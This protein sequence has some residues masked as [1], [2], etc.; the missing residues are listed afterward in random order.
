M[1]VDITAGSHRTEQEIGY[2]ADLCFDANPRDTRT[3]KA[4][5]SSLPIESS[6]VDLLMFDPPHQVYGHGKNSWLVDR[7]A[8]FE[9]CISAKESLE[10]A[11]SEISRVLKPNGVCLLKWST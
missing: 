1:I 5:W 2:F 10:R 6:S 8:S 11:F 4:E 9:N 7:Y 3:I